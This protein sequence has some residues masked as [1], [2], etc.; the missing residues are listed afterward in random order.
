MIHPAARHINNSCTVRRSLSSARCRSQPY[1]P[2]NS[3]LSTYD[4]VNCRQS[5]WKALFIL[6]IPNIYKSHCKSTENS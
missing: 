5:D 4:S 1:V 3:L 6:N 2:K